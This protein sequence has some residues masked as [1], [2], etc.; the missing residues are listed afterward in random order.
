MSCE[1]VERANA[2]LLGRA[3]YETA[4]IDGILF[5]VAEGVTCHAV[6]TAHC[7]SPNVNIVGDIV[8]ASQLEITCP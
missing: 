8:M 6:F 2:E 4:R 1:E 3:R 5:I 7:L